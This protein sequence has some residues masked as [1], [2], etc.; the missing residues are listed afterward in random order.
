MNF[1][2]AESYITSLLKFGVNLGLE[3]VEKYLGEKCYPWKDMKFIHVGGTNGKGSTSAMVARI[4]QEAGYRVGVYSSPHIDSYCQRI[5]INGKPI[6]R[7]S[8]AQIVTEIASAMNGVCEGDKLTEFEA[9]TVLALE[10]FRREHV[11]A[12]VIEVGM[13][14]R[15]DA[16][17]VIPHSEVSI[18]TNISRDHMEHL[19]YSTAEIAAEKA[20]IIKKGGCLVTAEESPEIRRM[21][22]DKCGELD[23][24]F[25]YIGDY[26]HW[27]LGEVRF[28]EGI[29]KQSCSISSSAFELPDL[30]LS[31]LGKHQVMNAAAAVLAAQV[32]V[33]NGFSISGPEVCRGLEQ[34]RL[35]GRFE[36]MH[37]NPL[38]VLDAAHN[39][40][41]IKALKDTILR[42]AGNKRLVLVTGVLDDKEQDKMVEAWGDLPEWIVVTRPEN[43]RSAAWEQLA[44]CFSRY[45]ENICIIENIQEAVSRG[46]ELAD[47][48]S[49]LCI[50]GSFYILKGARQRVQTLIN[51]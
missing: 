46:W 24:R 44:R 9:L 19:G 42:T 35:P 7:G 27:N 34:A 31:L 10:F 41:G 14:G 1:E 17:N 26:I 2:E 16:T 50:T 18:I 36:I 49:I 5:S 3:R 45:S 39:T 22:M 40:A 33:E 30:R 23:S 37:S 15:F 21:F 12:A 11:D 47:R 43:S 28:T 51:S 20:G 6:S 8:F 25:C 29:P 48:D 38:V 32:L 4:M 13:G